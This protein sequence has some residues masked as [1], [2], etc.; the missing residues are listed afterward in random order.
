MF[1][2][3]RKDPYPGQWIVIKE[4]MHKRLTMWTT[5]KPI[6]TWWAPWPAD[7]SDEQ[8]RLLR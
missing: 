4:G 2:E 7:E 5:S 8:K 6:P 3:Q 1:N